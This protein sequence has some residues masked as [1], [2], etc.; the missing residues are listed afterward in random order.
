MGCQMSRECTK[1]PEEGKDSS[2][3]KKKGHKKQDSQ[4]FEPKARSLEIDEPDQEQTKGKKWRPK[5]LE[6]PTHAS[7]SSK[8]NQASPSPMHAPQSAE[9]I[10]DLIEASKMQQEN[11][12]F[13]QSPHVFPVFER[14][15]DSNSNPL[16]ASL[17]DDGQGENSNSAGAVDASGAE[18]LKMM[19]AAKG[20][21]TRPANRHF[22]QSPQAR[23]EFGDY[24]DPAK[25]PS[26]Y[27]ESQMTFDE[28]SRKTPNG[29]PLRPVV[30]GNAPDEAKEEA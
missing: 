17:P 13:V 1:A 9:D 8:S 26:G 10:Q 3:K 19:Q 30:E 4:K 27:R 7:P 28:D 11:R 15:G 2:D 12:H 14:E 22:A 6:V 24:G 23:A 29:L 21:K 18:I 20:A 16:A 5:T 25:T